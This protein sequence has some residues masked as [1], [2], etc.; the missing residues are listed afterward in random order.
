MTLNWTKSDEKRAAKMGWQIYPIESRF[1]H[2]NTYQIQC[3]G[4][5]FRTDRE[6]AEWVLEQSYKAQFT[7]ASL[8]SKT[9]RRAVLLC[10]TGGAR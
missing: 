4:D 2:L 3:F 1:Q 7:A 6:A 5:T 9:Y 10:M 8:N